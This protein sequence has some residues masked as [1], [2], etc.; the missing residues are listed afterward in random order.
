[1]RISSIALF[2]VVAIYLA[3]LYYIFFVQVVG[4]DRSGYFENADDHLVPFKSTL[5]MFLRVKNEGINSQAAQILVVNIVGNL[6]L[7]VPFGLLAPMLYK[8]FKQL[9]RVLFAAMLFSLS[10]ECSQYLLKVGVFDVD[11]IILNTT[12]AGI[13]FAIYWCIRYCFSMGN[14]SQINAPNGPFRPQKIHYPGD[15]N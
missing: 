4:T 14:S 13:G 9:K 11:D 6:V 10:V 15:M 12:G 7:F 5:G 8:G 1:M 3:T 2:F